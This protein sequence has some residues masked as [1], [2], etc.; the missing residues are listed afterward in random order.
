MSNPTPPITILIPSFNG[1]ALLQKHLPGIL[2]Q[3]YPADEVIVVDDASDDG[4]ASYIEEIS[5]SSRCSVRVLQM[6]V[7]VRFAQAVNQG[8]L[9]AQHAHVFLCNND[10]SLLPGCLDVLRSHCLDK[11]LFAVGCLEYDKT[12]TGKESGK[13][14]LWFSQG[15]FHHSKADAFTPGNTAWVSG[16]SGLFDKQKW[17]ALNGFDT[18]FAP[19]YW[20]DVDISFQ[21]RGRGC[22]GLVAQT[23]QVPHQHE[24][25]H[26]AVFSAKKLRSMSWNHRLYFTWKHASFWQR[27]QFLF[28]LPYWILRQRKWQDAE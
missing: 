16:G 23:A 4:T 5:Q 8:F 28:W 20:E 22:R 3:V 1:L 27:L 9:A 10:V 15:L 26:S 12:T 11:N 7:T 14:K 13:N 17:Q 25:T 6:G 19:A 24:T 2:Q 18:H 21:A